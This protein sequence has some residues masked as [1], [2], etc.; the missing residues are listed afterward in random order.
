[1]SP[2]A[3]VSASPSLREH[4][5][6]SGNMTATD[7]GAIRPG[8]RCDLGADASDAD[9]RW[10]AVVAPR[11]A[12]PSP[13]PRARVDHGAA[14]IKV[15]VQLFGALAAHREERSLQFDQPAGTTV[16]DMLT[17]A[18]QR[19]GAPLLVHVLDERGAKRRHCRLFVDGYAVEDLR[20]ELDGATGRAEIDIIL[21]IA[22]E[23]G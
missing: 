11:A 21:L 7:A 16:I 9:V 8:R 17:V 6:A 13:T 18:E 20:R 1:M 4:V 22:P 3:H 19:L 5:S 10:D 12:A 2:Q 15:H 14:S 23:G